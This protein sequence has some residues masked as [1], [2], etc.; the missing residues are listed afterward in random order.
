[1]GTSAQGRGLHTIP[2]VGTVPAAPCPALAAFS[3]S[4]WSHGSKG[5]FSPDDCIRKEIMYEEL[6]PM[7]S[8]GAFYY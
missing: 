5:I 6:Q 2:E 8:I 7:K 1:M 3:A 4:K